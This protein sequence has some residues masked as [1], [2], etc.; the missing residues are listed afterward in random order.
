MV[1]NRTFLQLDSSMAMTLDQIEAEVS[2]L[3]EEDR[4]QLVNR[5]ASKLGTGM[6]KE[7]ES[8]WASEIRKRIADL[9]SGATATRNVDEVIAELLAESDASS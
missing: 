6:T 7:I 3:P 2:H 8:S 9:D 5:L 1:D 4:I